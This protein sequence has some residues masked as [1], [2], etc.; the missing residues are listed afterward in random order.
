M[1]I[2][3]LIAEKKR[4]GWHW[5]WFVPLCLCVLLF[6]EWYT[7]RVG[8]SVT[9]LAWHRWTWGALFSPSAAFC[10]GVI[11]FSVFAPLRLL[12]VIY[13]LVLT[14]QPWWWV[15]CLYQTSD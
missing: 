4:L 3:P 2:D 13:L 9:K 5:L 12:G 6:A 11:L 1:T 10:F 14:R 8:F 15:I 7:V